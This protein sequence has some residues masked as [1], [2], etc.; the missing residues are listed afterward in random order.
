MG[1]RTRMFS[2]FLKSFRLPPAP[3][4]IKGPDLGNGLQGGSPS[5]QYAATC[6]LPLAPSG[7]PDLGNGLPG[8]LLLAPSLKLF[9]MSLL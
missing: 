6:F 4:P 7:G 1:Y 3:G 5:F 9:I 8:R 2:L